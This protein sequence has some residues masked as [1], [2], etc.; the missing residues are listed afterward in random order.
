[1]EPGLTSPINFPNAHRTVR[2]NAASRGYDALV[3]AQLLTTLG[4][5]VKV[6]LPGAARAFVF[7]DAGLGDQT[8]QTAVGSLDA[9]GIKAGLRRIQVSETL[10]SLHTLGEMLEHLTVARLERSEPV[11][12]IGGGIL[13]DTAGL[14]AASYRRG[15][16]WI[17]CPTTLLSMVDA[18]V[19]GKTAVN[20]RAGGTLK[21]NMVG[22]FH[23][24]WLVLADTDT[25]KTLPDRMFRAGLAECV[26]HGLIGAD[27]GDPDLFGWIDQNAAAILRQDVGALSELIARNIAIKA[28]VVATDEREEAP[29]AAGGRALLNLGHTFAHA[30]EPMPT[31]SPDGDP[32]HAPLQHGEAVALGLV[33]ACAAAAHAPPRPPLPHASH[34]VHPTPPPLG[35]F[36]AGLTDRVRSLL[37]RLGLPVRVSGLPSAEAVLAAMG[38]DKKVASGKLRLVL[39]SGPGRCRVVLDPPREAILAGIAAIRA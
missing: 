20:I 30:I 7:A 18:S 13:G 24:P 31:L 27:W 29:D 17:N 23:Q 14:A 36:D 1:M 4:E 3:G 15:V 21:K 25:L 22:A 11:I 10:K 37:V 12:A 19:G 39:P 32:G 28:R 5:R 16:P 6:V 2:V 35:T 38:D 9:S 33:A 8:V 34:P 26:K